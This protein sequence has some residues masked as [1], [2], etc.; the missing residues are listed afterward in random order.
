MHKYKIQYIGLV[1][2]Y[3]CNLEYVAGVDAEQYYS[4]M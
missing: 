3:N 2:E 4:A 1:R